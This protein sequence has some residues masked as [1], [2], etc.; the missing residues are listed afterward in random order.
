M[1]SFPSSPNILLYAAPSINADMLWFSRF[2]ASDPF[3]AFSANGRR[4]AAMSLLEVTR[5]RK[6]SI[7]DEV[8]NL[9]ELGEALVRQGAKSNLADIIAA[10]AVRYKVRTFR[11]PPDFPVSLYQQITALGLHLEIGDAPFF[12]QRILKGPGEQA[13]IRAGNRA[14]SAG[15]S[16]VEQILA[17]SEIRQ[18]FVWHGGKVLTSELL[19]AAIDQTCLAHGALNV[20]GLIAAAGD[21]AVDCHCSGS[22]PIPANALIVVDIFPRMSASGYYG[23]MTRT[24]LKGRASAAQRRIVKTVREAQRLALSLIKPGVVGASIHKAVAAYFEAQGY[25]T[26]L[27]PANGYHEGFF[28]GL[29]HGL[30]LDVHEERSLSP[31]GTK[32]LRAGMVTTVEPGL[33]YLGLGGCRIEDV[34][35]VTETG[36]QLLSKHPYRWEIA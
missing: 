25:A 4:I 15:F 21:Q 35:L 28:H 22:G 31:R 16:A 13:N 14:A 30:G 23:D 3:L 7:L 26:G 8:L 11:V 32:V 20:S 34:A 29:G 6:E 9:Q 5:A 1:A 17:A 18:G 33:Y 27:N 19:R 2:H 12:P 10:L 36:H 24:Y